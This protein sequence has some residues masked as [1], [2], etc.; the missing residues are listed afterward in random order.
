MPGE[1]DYK[2]IEK[3][4]KFPLLS[5]FWIGFSIFSCFFSKEVFSAGVHIIQIIDIFATHP[6]FSKMI[7]FP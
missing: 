3:K 2:W 4:F 1:K 5:Q 6:P 7:F